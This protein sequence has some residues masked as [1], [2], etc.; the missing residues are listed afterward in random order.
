MKNRFAPLGAILSV[1][2][3]L[4]WVFSNARNDPSVF[5]MEDSLAGSASTSTADEFFFRER[6]GGSAVPCAVPLAWRIARVDESFGLSRA[7]ARTALDQAATLWEEA[8]GT[9]V[10]SNEADGDLSVRFVYDDR[11]ERTRQIRRLELEFDE[12]SA[13]LENRRAGLDELSRRNDGMRG[14]HREALRDL[15]RRVTSLNDSIREWNAQGGAPAELRAR[16]GTSGSL[17]DAEREAL[18]DRGRE[19]EELQQQLE[20]EFERLNREV[21]AHQR[22]ADSLEA[23]FPMRRRQSGI[24]REAVHVQDGAVTSVTREIRIFRFDGSDDLVRVAAHELGHALGLAHNAVQ[25]GIMRAEITR[26]VLS[27]GPPRVQ[28]GDVE[29]LRLLCPEL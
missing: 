1:L 5:E 10:F 15:D 13:S 6:T 7:E 22:E 19:I 25:G 12:A 29:V 11:Q 4:A 9:D 8:L 3:F 2:A 26:T 24:Y 21:E 23:S 17:L 28:P 18:T 14:E 20:D 16:L 27:E